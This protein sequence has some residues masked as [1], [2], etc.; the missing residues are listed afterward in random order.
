MWPTLAYPAHSHFLEPGIMT[1]VGG[2]CPRQLRASGRA[3]VFAVV[4]TLL[5]GAAFGQQ[6]TPEQMPNFDQDWN[7]NM[8]ETM[9][10]VQEWQDSQRQNDLRFQEQMGAAS[11][12]INDAF[13]KNW[14]SFTSALMWFGVAGLVVASLLVLAMASGVFVRLRATTDPMKLAMSDPWLRAQ[15]AR[16]VDSTPSALAEASSNQQFS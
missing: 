6:Y 16:D 10:Q 7:R 12:D 3:A 8:E 2:S 1:Q 4:V 14:Q 5:D 11:K 15:M 9:R 13:D